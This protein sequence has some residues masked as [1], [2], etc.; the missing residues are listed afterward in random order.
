MVLH[1]TLHLARNTLSKTFTHGY[2]QSVVAA[3]QSSYAS[4][5]N[6]FGLS[7]F[8]KTQSHGFHKNA[9][10]QTG[11]DQTESGGLNAYY[12][13]W[14]KSQKL[15]DKDWSQFQFPKRIEWKP[16]APVTDAK[17]SDDVLIEVNDPLPAQAVVDRSYSTSAV[18]DFRKIV[19]QEAEYVALQKVDEEIKSEIAR[20]KE[21]ERAPEALGREGLEAELISPIAEGLS[22]NVSPSE[23]SFSAASEFSSAT[24][25][26][27]AESFADQLQTLAESRHYAVI[28]AVFEQMLSRGITPIPSAYN[29]LLAA[30]IRLPK[31]RQE[32]VSKA[33]DVYSDIVKRRVVPD[34]A[35]YTTLV[36]L[37]SSRAL[38]V[39][40]MKNVL[41]E[42]RTRY[43]G[44]EEDGSFLLKSSYSELD[45]LAADSSLT[46]AVR[47]FE[48]ATSVH[49]KEAFAERTYCYLV[50]ALA[51]HGKV[52]E[53]ARIYSHMEKHGIIPRADTFVNMI[54]AFA[55]AGDL[56]NA[57]E[58]YNE[59]K[60]YAVSHNDG[61][62]KMARKD[63]DVYAAVVKAF[64]I[65]QKPEGASQFLTKLEASVS[66]EQ[67]P[68]LRDIIGLK[69]FIPEWLNQGY[70]EEAFNVAN[71][72]LTG[73]ARDI[74]L[75]AVAIRAADRNQFDV[76]T[77]SFD[78]LS[79]K[80]DVVLPAMA[81]GAMHVRNRDLESA[82]KYWTVIEGSHSTPA[83]IES[84]T[85]HTIG[86]VGSGQ[87]DAGLARARSMFAKVRDAHQDSQE[88]V[89]RINEAL[90][91]ISDF[92]AKR[93][94]VVSALAAMELMRAMVD[95]HGLTPAVSAFVLAHLGPDEIA[96]LSTEDLS[97]L[98]Q[99][100]SNLIVHAP[101]LDIASSARFGH[102]VQML[103]GS[104]AP[105]NAATEEAIEQGLAKIDR[106]DLLQQWQHYK[107]PIPIT[108]AALSPYHAFVPV[109]SPAP[110]ATF[111]DSYDPYASTTDG[112]GSAV[113]ADLLEKTH[114]NFSN[115]LK[116]AL[117]RF[118]NMRR[119]G[120]H[121]RFYTY[122][123]L[124]TA[125]AKDNNL[126]LAHDILAM[127]KQDVPY[128]PQYRIVRHGWATILD[129]MVSACLTTGQR[130]M[131]EQYHQ[132][133][134][135]MGSAPS[136]NT[137]GQY[138]TTLKESTK[139]FDEASEAVNIF[140][141]AKAEGVEP[142]SFLYNVL[143][144]KLGKAR[145]IDDCLFYYQ[146]MRNLG[147]HPTSVTYGT[148]IN[149]LCR[150]SDEKFAEEIFEEMES[151]PNYKPRPAPYH[152]IMQY[153]LNTK[154]D[155]G[156]VLQYYERMRSKN[157]EHTSY[158][159]KLLIDTYATLEPIDMDAAE[160]VLEIIRKNGELPE[161]V[162]YASLI[163][164]KG[165]VLR[166]M[167]GAKKLFETV[168]ANH[169]VRLQPCLF[170]ALF[171]AMVANHQVQDT[172]PILALM[173]SRGIE[174]TPY[175]ANGLIHGWSL[176][177]DIK[178]AEGIYKKVKP[179]AR[180][181][182]LYEAMTRAY[183]ANSEQEKAMDVVREATSRGYPTAV[184]NKIIDLVAHDTGVAHPSEQQQ[185]QASVAV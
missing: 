108:P 86:L 10:Q 77:K 171:E 114:G 65:A 67:L 138:I 8:G 125:A 176:V 5:N 165:C 141:R 44:L 151:M 105:L 111:E 89:E 97:L 179:E 115:H 148:I 15:A 45:A 51:E 74:G 144:G 26:S 35:T 56:P 156:K 145:R 62:V 173:K 124:I 113:I 183:V 64:T 40:S 82:E 91:L 57:M 150:V 168:L 41:E 36:E 126:Q 130:H 38:E 19:D 21:V 87:A 63:N 48:E 47:M 42:K 140:L 177:K 34:L 18:D 29:A 31:T 11:K 37:L 120:R 50:S 13:A 123:K 28:P 75:K 90:V 9:G 107:Q 22:S 92:M 16:S 54:R 14:H 128:V 71:E 119:L 153:F 127:A 175:I 129:A 27:E 17:A 78:H 136:A 164:A 7:R 33:L 132:E 20:A 52:D 121:P 134:L 112:K 149:A 55:T 30:A 103:L 159:Y 3:T 83:L 116:E 154:R 102:I 158:T 118:K 73:A 133:L 155:R 39:A 137:F 88:V 152:S 170:Q 59:Y 178:K 101:H 84:T 85:M 142:S 12:A 163:H 157:I 146:E 98:T 166:N 122:G 96:H 131:A 1:K 80:T 58:T 72:K 182:S 106:P 180:E 49:S 66:E 143:I 161:A 46:E 147:I 6:S 23:R 79:N 185:Q 25:V 69:A 167:E 24:P 61:K 70:F 76:A 53:M 68:V 2:A 181:P 184:Q 93:G 172:E 160:N 100:Q 135:K 169:R 162:H 110:S 43:G 95:N 4:Q 94:I 81:L 32:S 104:G 117:T 139:T 99:V 60:E 109:A 174:I